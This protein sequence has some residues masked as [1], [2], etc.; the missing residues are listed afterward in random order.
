[1]SDYVSD[2]LLVLSLV[3]A[4]IVLGMLLFHGLSI[5]DH[6][7]RDKGS[8]TLSPPKGGSSDGRGAAQ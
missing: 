4:P 7:H 1:M 5:S 8:G 6:R 2:V 3:G